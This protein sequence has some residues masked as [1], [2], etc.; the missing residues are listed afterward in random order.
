MAR[1]LQ[2]CFP[3]NRVRTTPSEVREYCSN[4]IE[5]CV[6]G[7]GYVPAGGCVQ[8]IHKPENIQAVRAAGKEFS[9]YRKPIAVKYGPGRET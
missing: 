1:D 7:G 3:A 8:D 9:V 5:T 6:P 4:L 2:P